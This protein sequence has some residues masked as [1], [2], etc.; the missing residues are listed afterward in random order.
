MGPL[1]KDL[2]C[3]GDVSWDH[4]GF[5]L[6]EAHSVAF[7]EVLRHCGCSVFSDVS[8]AG[9]SAKEGLH[10]RGGS[11]L[12]SYE[13]FDECMEDSGSGRLILSCSTKF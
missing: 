8:V 5:W 1:K 11:E 6:R 2:T 10:V 3:V 12:A 9:G 13:D 4:R 7:H